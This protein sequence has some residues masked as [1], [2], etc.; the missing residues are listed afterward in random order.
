MCEVSRNTG[1]LGVERVQ[2]SWWLTSNKPVAQVSSC[3]RETGP[4]HAGLERFG[5]GQHAHEPNLAAEPPGT[6]LGI[7]SPPSNA[8]FTVYTPCCKSYSP[9]RAISTVKP[10]RRLWLTIQLTLPTLLPISIPKHGRHG[11]A[12]LHNTAHQRHHPGQ[13]CGWRDCSSHCRRHH[14]RRYTPS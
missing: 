12:F 13:R 8:A 6:R 5:H 11:R 4:P 14:L 3:C 7:S 10:S 9:R 1:R 2:W